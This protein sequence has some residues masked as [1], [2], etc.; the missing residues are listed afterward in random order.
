MFRTNTEPG[1]ALQTWHCQKKLWPAYLRELQFP[2]FSP[3]DWQACCP[4]QAL[5]L[6]RDAVGSGYLQQPPALGKTHASLSLHA[7]T[8]GVAMLTLRSWLLRLQQAA[9]RGQGLPATL[10]IACERQ[11]G[12]NQPVSAQK[13]TADA[14]SQQGAPLVQP[15]MRLAALLVA[16]SNL[17]SSEQRLK[18]RSFG[19]APARLWCPFAFRQSL[20]HTG[21]LSQLL[22]PHLNTRCPAW[23]ASG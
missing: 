15:Q 9:Q 19:A 2:T 1:V 16:Q 3:P 17:H 4:V 20:L 8:A 13:S 5:A 22:A 10:A 12:S 11:H 23:L 7:M 18:A 14:H 21:L 6:F